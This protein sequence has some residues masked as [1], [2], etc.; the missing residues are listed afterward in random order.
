MLRAESL[1]L[2]ARGNKEGRKEATKRFDGNV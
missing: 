1:K 2:R